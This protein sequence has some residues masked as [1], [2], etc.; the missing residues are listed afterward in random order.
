M[1]K[2]LKKI[3][4]KNIFS[5]IVGTVIFGVINVYAVTYYA[6]SATN[7]DN[8][9]SKMK[10]TNVQS[11]IDEL[12]TVC[13]SPK[14]AGDQILNNV[15]IVTSGDGLYQ[16]EYETCRYLYKGSTPNNY[17][18]FNGDNAGW[19]IISIEC[20]G[21]IKIMKQE[22]FVYSTWDINTDDN[23]EWIGSGIALDLNS[24]YGWWT[25]YY[26]VSEN[27]RKQIVS[28]NFNVGGVQF[29]FHTLQ[30]YISKEKQVKWTGKVGLVSLSEYIRANSNQKQ[31]VNTTTVNENY[32]ICKN[33]NWMNTNFN[34][35]LSTVDTNQIKRAGAVYSYGQVWGTD[36]WDNDGSASLAQRP[37]VYLSSDIKIIGGDGSQNNPY[38]IE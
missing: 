21:T 16:D 7:Y 12:Y 4:K 10:S 23:A 28:H 14:S 24:E 3:K 5:F 19:R 31:C 38:I 35:W 22:S 17:I 29:E 9:T 33:T 30:E 20:D 36:V 15:N 18:T 6:S 8:S 26:T 13:S 1:K 11:A 2:Q 27:A 32:N 37:V 25:F 34:W